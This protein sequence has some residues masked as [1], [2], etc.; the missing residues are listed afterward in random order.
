MMVWKTLQDEARSD[1]IQLAEKR[2]LAKKSSFPLLGVSRV[3]R[4]CVWQPGF[5]LSRGL[6]TEKVVM[7]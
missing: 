5:C 7:I 2:P 3:M 4:L 6:D 1:I